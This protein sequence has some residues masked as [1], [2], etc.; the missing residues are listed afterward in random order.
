MLTGLMV[1]SRSSAKQQGSDRLTW[2]RRWQHTRDS[3]S[4]AE[5]MKKGRVAA[6]PFSRPR[7]MFLA[8][9]SGE[10]EGDD[11][12]FLGASGVTCPMNILGACG[13]VEV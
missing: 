2:S 1:H 9:C 13:S 8:R 5:V 3:K 12:D 4:G 7:G 11:P 6:I 10:F